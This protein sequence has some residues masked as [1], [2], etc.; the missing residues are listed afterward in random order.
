MKIL[1][2]KG[3]QNVLISYMIVTLNEYEGHPNWCQNPGLS[4]LNQHNKIKEICRLMSGYKPT[5]IVLMESLIGL[6][7]LSS[8]Q[9]FPSKSNEDFV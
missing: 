8:T 1:E 4:N 5:M 7:G 6:L 3:E 2:G 9:K